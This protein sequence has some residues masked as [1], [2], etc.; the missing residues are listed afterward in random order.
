[1]TLNELIERLEELREYGDDT[2]VEVNDNEYFDLGY[3]SRDNIIYIE[4]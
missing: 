3:D 4:S 1:M 2:T